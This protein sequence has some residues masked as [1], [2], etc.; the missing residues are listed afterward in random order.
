MRMVL[1]CSRVVARYDS[2]RIDLG[3]RDRPRGR[4]ERRRHSR[5][6]WISETHRDAVDRPGGQLRTRE[7]RAEG[8]ADQPSKRRRAQAS[9]LRHSLRTRHPVG[10][11]LCVAAHAGLR[12]Q[13]AVAAVFAAVYTGDVLLNTALGLYKPTSWTKQDIVID[14]GEKLI[15]AEATSAVF[16]RFLDPAKG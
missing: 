15:Q 14:V 5:D 8:P 9:E 12:G 10:Q 16:D 11:R 2:E 6:D 1:P 13:R 3:R 4:R 7:L